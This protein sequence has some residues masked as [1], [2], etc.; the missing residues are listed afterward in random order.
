M[1]SS[2]SQ[3]AV[4]AG[5]SV[6]A[7]GTLIASGRT[8]TWAV[9][10]PE[11]DDGRAGEAAPVFVPLTAAEPVAAAVP[12]AAALLAAAEAA[13]AAAVTAVTQAARVILALDMQAP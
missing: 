9:D 4:E 3:S 13:S 12:V 8:V 6:G 11:A 7:P 2:C 1:P 5:T 10:A